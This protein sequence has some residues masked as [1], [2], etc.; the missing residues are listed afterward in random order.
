[1]VTVS[2]NPRLEENLVSSNKFSNSKTCSV[3][4][5]ISPQAVFEEVHLSVIVQ[6]PLKAA[7]EAQF[8]S[9]LSER[10][11]VKCKVY[12]E[13]D[14]NVPSLELEVNVSFISNLGVPRVLRKV[15]HLPL[16]LV[17]DT[18]SAVKDNDN[19]IILNI[20]KSIVPLSALFP[21]K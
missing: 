18:C 11:E 6:K 14:L 3:T 12:L 9:N 5:D 17:V 13:N 2:V 21:G 4:V 10:S 15:A 20:N 7:P 16:T 8:F 19:K 1:M